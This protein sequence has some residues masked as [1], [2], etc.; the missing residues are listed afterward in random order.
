LSKSLL[1][2]EHGVAGREQENSQNMERNQVGVDM[3]KHHPDEIS[4]LVYVWAGGSLL[5]DTKY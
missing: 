5:K 1:I 3:G 2:G 4:G